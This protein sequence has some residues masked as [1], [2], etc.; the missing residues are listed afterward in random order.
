MAATLE[1]IGGNWK[2]LILFHLRDRAMGFSE[3]QRVV[4]QITQKMLDATITR[5]RARRDHP[6]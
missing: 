4:P 5:P 2:P 1:V 6:S 3:L